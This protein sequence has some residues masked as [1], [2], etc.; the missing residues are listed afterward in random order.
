MKGATGISLRENAL[1]QTSHTK[2]HQASRLRD[3]EIETLCTITTSTANY[4]G[5][6]TASEHAIVPHMRLKLPWIPQQVS[7][8]LRSFLC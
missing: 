1:G 5:A 7:L 4:I 6:H 8:Q 3:K 2:R